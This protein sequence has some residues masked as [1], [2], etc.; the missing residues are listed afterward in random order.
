MLLRAQSFDHL[1]DRTCEFADLIASSASDLDV[2]LT[3]AD[4]GQAFAYRAYVMRY[5][6]RQELTGANGYECGAQ[7]QRNDQG[8]VV[9]GDEHAIGAD[10]DR[11]ER[12]SERDCRGKYEL[13]PQAAEAPAAG[14]SGMRYEQ[15]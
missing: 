14:L 1:L 4:G 15:A 8:G 6:R 7:H 9:V 12:C 13:A 11:G 10:Y 2:T 5:T 3:V